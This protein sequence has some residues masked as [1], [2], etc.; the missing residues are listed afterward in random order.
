MLYLNNNRD[1]RDMVKVLTIFKDGIFSGQTAFSF[2]FYNV[3]SSFKLDYIVLY[4]LSF[5]KPIL[6]ICYLT[7]HLISLISLLSTLEKLKN[8]LE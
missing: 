6:Q 3:Y 7:F 5:S 2:F 1:Q 4:A 8:V